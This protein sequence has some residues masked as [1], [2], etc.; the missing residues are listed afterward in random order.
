[1]LT[2]DPALEEK[3]PYNPT[4]CLLDFFAEKR[5]ELDTHATWST[6]E[7]DRKEFLK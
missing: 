5:D 7:K 6:A 3:A 1:M 2:L 4:E